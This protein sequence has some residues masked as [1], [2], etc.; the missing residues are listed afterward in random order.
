M[1]L[2]SKLPDNKLLL[3]DTRNYFEVSKIYNIFF[4]TF[5]MIG[6]LRSINQFFTIFYGVKLG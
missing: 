4:D 2:F 3:N 6:K 5:R 1:F